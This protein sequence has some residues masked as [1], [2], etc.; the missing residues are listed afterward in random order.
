MQV[1]AVNAHFPEFTIAQEILNSETKTLPISAERNN[2]DAKLCDVCV[3]KYSHEESP[4]K[5]VKTDI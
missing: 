4:S 5:K 2:V 1:P 3:D